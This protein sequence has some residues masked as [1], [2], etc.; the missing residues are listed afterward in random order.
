MNQLTVTGNLTRDAECRQI[1]NGGYMTRFTVAANRTY[2]VNGEQKE[3]ADFI[4]VTKFGNGAM[5]C[6]DLK[7]GEA[8][9]VLGR[10]ETRKYEAN[11][12]TKYTT[13]LNAS[14]VA[15]PLRDEPHDP[16]AFSRF[17]AKQYTQGSFG[18]DIPF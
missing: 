12:E 2:T 16:D 1:K 13:Y 6:G 14:S 17:G 3:A 11:G 15:T 8:V 7:K 9:V 18:E 4:P 5:A 10:F